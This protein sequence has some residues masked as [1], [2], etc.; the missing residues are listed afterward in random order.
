MTYLKTNRA[1]IGKT[2]RERWEDGLVEGGI[3]YIDMDWVCG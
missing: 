1:T 2:A 3:V